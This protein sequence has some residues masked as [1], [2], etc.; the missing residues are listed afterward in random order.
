MRHIHG[1]YLADHMSGYELTT[2]IEPLD[3]RIEIHDAIT[4]ARLRASP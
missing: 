3:A 2:L 1:S 4:Q